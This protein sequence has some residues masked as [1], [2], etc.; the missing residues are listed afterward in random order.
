[1]ATPQVMINERDGSGPRWPGGRQVKQP[2]RSKKGV[3]RRLQL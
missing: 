2:L 3:R 1:M